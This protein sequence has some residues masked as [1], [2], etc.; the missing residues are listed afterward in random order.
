MKYHC[1]FM[2]SIMRI[3]K[4]FFMH[5]FKKKTPFLSIWVYICGGPNLQMKS[6]VLEYHDAADLELY[7]RA[8]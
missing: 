7:S 6:R 2:Y 4:V 5:N 1:L 3:R 8:T